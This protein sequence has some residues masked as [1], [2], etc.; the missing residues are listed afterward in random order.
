MCVIEEPFSIIIIIIIYIYMI[1]AYNV[2]KQTNIIETDEKMFDNYNEGDKR[3]PRPTAMM[4]SDCI[5]G[6]Q[7]RHLVNRAGCQCHKS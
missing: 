7:W 5:V 6:Q 3:S 1:Y 4:L 2:S